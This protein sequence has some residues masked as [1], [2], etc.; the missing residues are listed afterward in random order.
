MN[1]I[2]SNLFRDIHALPRKFVV[3]ILKVFLC[4]N[5]TFFI[6][7]KIAFKN[8]KSSSKFFSV[9]FTQKFSLHF[10]KR[11]LVMSEVIRENMFEWIQR[12]VGFSTTNKCKTASFLHTLVHLGTQTSAFNYYYNKKFI[13]IQTHPDFFLPH[14]LFC[15]FCL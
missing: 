6:L 15:F 1:E 3:H 10:L 7:P 5:I 12:H 9:S 13:L 11:L 8:L 14:R 2:I 4:K